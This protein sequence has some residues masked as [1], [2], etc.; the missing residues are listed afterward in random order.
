MAHFAELDENNIV[1]R[2]VVVGN[3]NCLGDD[4]NESEAVGIAWCENFFGGGTWIQTSFNTWGGKHWTT[5]EEPLGEPS[6]EDDG[7]PFRKNYAGKGHTYDSTRDAF[8]DP[9]PEGSWTLNEDT[10]QWESE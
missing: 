3:E 6:T 1:T 7:T 4:G 10:C 2:V 8:Y 9:Q 5:G